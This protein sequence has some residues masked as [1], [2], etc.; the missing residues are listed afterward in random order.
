M[1]DFLICL[2]DITQIFKT[3]P[4]KCSWQFIL[5]PSIYIYFL[6]DRYSDVC[7]SLQDGA[8]SAS[9]I[10]WAAAVLVMSARPLN[11][12][13]GSLQFKHKLPWFI[14]SGAGGVTNLF[15]IL[16]TNYKHTLINHVGTDASV[17]CIVLCPVLH[18]WKTKVK[19]CKNKHK[20]LRI[21]Y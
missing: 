3:I 19:L 21:F 10:L 12:W 16:H 1:C 14:E 17:V 8:S 20:D 9:P 5:I 7:Y 4:L 11:T 15:T 2:R 13:C 6:K 18:P